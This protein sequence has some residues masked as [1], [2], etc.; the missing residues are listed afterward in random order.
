MPLPIPYRCARNNPIVTHSMGSILVRA[1]LSAGD[2]ARVGR[3]VMLAPPHGGSRVA[4]LFSGLLGSICKPLPQL[5]HTPESLVNNLPAPAGHDIGIIAAS[6]DRMVHVEHTH[7]ATQSDH[8]V[9]PG[10]HTTIL[11]RPNVARLVKSFLHSGSFEAVEPSA[12]KD[13]PSV[14]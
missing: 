13:L 10:G 5:R 3:V 8:I 11:F 9:V 2:Y 14:V 12:V 7:L 1:A 6:R 4:T